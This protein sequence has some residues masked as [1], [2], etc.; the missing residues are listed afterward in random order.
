MT[1]GVQPEERGRGD[2]R[3][4]ALVAAAYQAI[5]QKGFEGL[6]VRDVAAAVGVNN[7][8]LHYYFPTK[9]DLIRAVLAFV[10]DE[11]LTSRT[12]HVGSRKEDAL[13]RLR[14][15][16]KAVAKEAR[17]T[18]EPMIVLNELTARAARDETIRGPL[19]EYEE[20]WLAAFSSVLRE[21]IGEGLFRADLDVEGTAW[22]IKAIVREM[23]S[24][25]NYD[26][27][28]VNR[29]IEQLERWLRP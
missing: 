4:R 16:F 2:E 24:H 25:L 14:Q 17:S 27:L 6:R 18:P 13:Q 1:P 8:T 10:I 15:Y 12:M 29:S 9:E 7:A 19:R 21:G 23:S 3:R 26:P 20:R 5:A 22:A 28:R 11:L